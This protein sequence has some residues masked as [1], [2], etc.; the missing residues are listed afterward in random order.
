M[1]RA[2]C[3]GA[4]NR[5]LLFS[6]VWL[7][8]ITDRGGLSRGVPHVLEALDTWSRVGDTVWVGLGGVTLLKD[9]V[10]VPAPILRFQKPSSCSRCT[11]SASWLW[12]EM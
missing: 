5:G 3:R 2:G 12:F 6:A 10:M 9:Y 7:A 1:L 4:P 8:R 11:L